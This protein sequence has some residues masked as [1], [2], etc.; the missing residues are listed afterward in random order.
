MR[1]ERNTNDAAG[2]GRQQQQHHIKTKTGDAFD[3]SVSFP[4][5]N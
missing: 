5:K 1:L 2:D 3:Y 4:N